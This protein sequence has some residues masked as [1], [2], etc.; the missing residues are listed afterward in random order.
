MDIVCGDIYSS[1]GF[2]FLAFF[3]GLACA[4]GGIF[5]QL[6]GDCIMA[7]CLE[8]TIVIDLWLAVLISLRMESGAKQLL[9]GF[10][11]GAVEFF[12][13]EKEGCFSVEWCARK[14][15]A[16]SWSK[17]CR[18]ACKFKVSKPV[19]LRSLSLLLSSNLFAVPS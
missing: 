9:A 19:T 1:L 3:V 12:R 5:F 15:S 16:S 13:V 11:L 2:L 6:R 10:S 7:L 18:H 17:S 8:C 14:F 4:E